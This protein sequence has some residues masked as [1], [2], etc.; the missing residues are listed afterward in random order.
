M[1]IARREHIQSLLHVGHV[2]VLDG[3]SLHGQ[4]RFQATSSPHSLGK[5]EPD[6]RSSP[7]SDPQAA[8]VGF[9][10]RRTLQ[11]SDAARSECLSG[12]RCKPWIRPRS[13][14]ASTRGSTIEI[15]Y[16]FV[17]L[18]RQR[19]AACGFVAAKLCCLTIRNPVSHQH[20]GDVGFTFLFRFATN[21]WWK[22]SASGAHEANCGA[23]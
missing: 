9:C 7:I 19:N 14:H 20:G 15:A 11:L 8:T 2:F 6:F 21:G 23:Q 4:F 5:C 22:F 18:H 10:N 3:V 1:V 16:S 17:L 13:S 12:I